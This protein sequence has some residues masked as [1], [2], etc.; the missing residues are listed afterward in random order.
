MSAKK[1][2]EPGWTYRRWLVFPSMAFSMVQ[3]E[4]LRRTESV[5]VAKLLVYT[6][7]FTMVCMVFFYTGFATIQDVIAII[8]TGRGLPY[9]DEAPSTTTTFEQKVV[10][11]SATP[12]P[13]PESKIE[14]L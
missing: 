8:K 10:T 7:G 4:L 2:G 12:T 3:L 5:E 13:E 6:H 9:K 1:T 11:N 14:G